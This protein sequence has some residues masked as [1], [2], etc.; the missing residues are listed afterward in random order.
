MSNFSLIISSAVLFLLI[1]LSGF[2]SIS[3]TALMAINRYRL[4]HRARMRK[5]SAMVVLKLLKR[6]D[7]LLSMILIGNTVAN[8]FASALATLLAVHLFDENAVVPITLILTFVI[9]VFCEVAPKTFA[10]I[11]PDKIARVVAFPIA[12]LLKL[13][14]PLVWLINTFANSILR[15]IGIKISNLGVEPLSREELRSVVFEGTG[16]VPHQYQSMLLGILDLNQVTVDDAMIPKHEIIGIDLEKNWNLDSATNLYDWLPVYRENINNI[17]GVLHTRELLRLTMKHESINEAALLKILQ[18]PYFIPQGTFLNIQLQNFK[19]KHKRMALVVDEYGEI[20]GLIT[21]KD[22]LEEIVG[23]FTSSVSAV[24][25]MIEVQSDGSYLVDG[26]VT[27][28][29]LNRVT[30]WTFSTKGPRTLNGLIIEYLEMIPRAGIGFKI[31]DHPIEILDVKDNRVKK[32]RIYA[33][34]VLPE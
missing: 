9:L 16:K 7:R 21:L 3:E 17:V 15:L 27:I 29:E 25:K 6:P 26:A 24:N 31:A 22:I 32:A 33:K 8:I 34:V 2:F 14:Y 11:Y 30:H 12:F 19:Q 20:L 10:A 5:R 23:E 18:E 4:R 28:R 13:F 1:L